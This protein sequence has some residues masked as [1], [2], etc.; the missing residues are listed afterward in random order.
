MMNWVLWFGWMI[1]RSAGRG[2]FGLRIEGW[3]HLI[4]EGPVLVVANHESYLDP[5]LLESLY[6]DEMY[7][8]ARKS[9]FRGFTNWLYRR[10]LAIPVDQ[11]RPDMASLK[12]IIRLLREGNRVL[13]FPEGSRTTDGSIGDAQ[14][15]IGLIAVKSGAPIQPLRISGAR[16]A[17]PRGSARLRF[18][19]ITIRIGPAIRLTPEEIRDAHSK[20]GYKRLAERMM[21]AVLELS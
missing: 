1:F 8:L 4:E 20:D 17:L 11:N 9:L 18:A 15:G 6:H 5:P 14:P 21:R 19:R 10:W 3:E 16:D 7:V 2:L 13:V 12:I